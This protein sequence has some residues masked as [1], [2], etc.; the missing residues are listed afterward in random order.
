MKIT[1]FKSYDEMSEAAAEIFKGQINKK[2]DSV[3][4]LAT[5]STPIGLY[6][7]LIEFYNEGKVDFSKVITF[8]LD[9]YVGLDE[10]SDQSYKYFMAHNL[11]DY[12][13]VKKEN[14]HIPDGCAKDLQKECSDYNEAVEK[15]G[16]IDLQIL[17]IGN[18]GHIGFNE[19]SETLYIGTHITNLTQ[20]TIK[21]NSR[22]FKNIDD[23]PTKAITMGMGGI[24]K[25][26]KIILLANGKNKAKIIKQLVE[27]NLNPMLPASVLKLHSSLEVIIDEDAA[28]LLN[29]VC[30]LQNKKIS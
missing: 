13:N 16:G 1:V 28:S 6:E 26:K 24:M 12:V 17:G 2:P 20:S 5:G 19:P 27:S 29:D 8:N 11:F 14:I 22:F 30:N 9:E 3:L 7:K 10:R 15:S 18:N 4:G 25:A 21:A 23:V